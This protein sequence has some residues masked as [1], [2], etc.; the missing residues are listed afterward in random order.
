MIFN[1]P[2][3]LTLFRL[4]LI[5]VFVVVFYLPVSW[6]YFAAAAI[7]VLASITDYL[8]GYLARR[9]N[10]ST[11]FGAFL[12]PVADK[13]MVA[14]SLVLLAEH[15]SV[16]WITLPAAIMIS[17]EIVISALREWMAEL[18]KRGNVAVSLLGKVKTATQMVAI[19]GLIWQHNE[20][21]ITLA[22]ILLY[23]ATLLTFW[24]MWLYLRAAWQDLARR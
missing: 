10:Q 20:L 21:I 6:A 22:V 15:Y 7:F 23:V 9:L 13:V 5:P 12:D 16:W 19:T 14:I 1:I 8:D 3:A 4:L 18:G 17:R 2:I 11:E 24:S